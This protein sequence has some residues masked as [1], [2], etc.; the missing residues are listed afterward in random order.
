MQ[1]YNTNFGSDINSFVGAA[2]NMVL[3]KFVHWL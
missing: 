3:F 1:I 2:V